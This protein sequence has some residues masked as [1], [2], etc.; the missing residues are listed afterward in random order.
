MRVIAYVDGFNLYFGLRYSGY[1][2]Y[3]WLNIQ[4]MV[5]NLV[6]PHQQLLMTKYFTARISGPKKGDISKVALNL[7]AKRRRQTV[8]LEPL[9]TLTG[10]KIYYAH[11]LSEEV[12]CPSGYASL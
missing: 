7:E 10:F 8:F 3:Y 9:E 5:K 1:K 2:R 12:E 4:A 6:R 11:Y